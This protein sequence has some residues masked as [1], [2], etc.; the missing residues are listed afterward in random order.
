MSDLNEA[1]VMAA[2][3]ELA[4]LCDDCANEPNRHVAQARRAINAYMQ[5]VTPKEDG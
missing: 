2:A 3:R 4:W 5:A 1:G